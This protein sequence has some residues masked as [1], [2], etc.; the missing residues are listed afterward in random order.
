MTGIIFRLQTGIINQGPHGS[1]N[2][3]NA[4]RK[5]I[6]KS[7]S[8]DG[9]ITSYLLYNL[10]ESGERKNRQSPFGNLFSGIPGY[11]LIFG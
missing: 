9:H 10:P 7:F 5:I 8:A 6:V 11:S 3:A 4:P 1:V 2:D